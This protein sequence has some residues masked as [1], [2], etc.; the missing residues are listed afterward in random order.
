MKD[1]IFPEWALKY[2]EKGMTLRKKGKGYALLKVTS[3]YV[4]GSYPKLSQTYLG[5]VTEEGFHPAKIDLKKDETSFFEWGLSSY[6]FDNYHRELQRSCYGTSGDIKEAIIKLGIVYFAH[7]SISENI[8]KLCA[9]TYQEIDVLSKVKNTTSMSRI[10]AIKNKIDMLFKRDFSDEDTRNELI[11]L[12]RLEMI[13]KS[14]DRTKKK[15]SQM[16]IEI[17]ERVKNETK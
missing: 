8:L 13:H 5:M 17:L 7:G 6:I 16:V 9:L 1:T 14:E 3:T 12:M 15:H 11:A 4:K 10:E 2:K